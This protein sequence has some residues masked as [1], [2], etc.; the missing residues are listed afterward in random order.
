MTLRTSPLC[1]RLLSALK[2]FFVGLLGVGC[3]CRC[4]HRRTYDDKQRVAAINAVAPDCQCEKHRMSKYSPGVVAHSESLAR[5]VFSPMHVHKKNGTILPSIFSHVFS[6]GCSIQRNSLATVAELRA[7]VTDFIEEDDKRSWRGI[8]L[9]DCDSIRKI[10]DESNRR[11]A[12][13]YDSAEKNNPSHGEICQTQYVIDEADQVELRAALFEA[14]NHG[15][16]TL[17]S[18]YRNGEVWQQI[19]EDLRARTS[20]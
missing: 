14:F 20:P 15:V 6:A 10:K 19:P 9:A 11:L 12:C 3:K 13:V 7:F 18:Q 1:S 16:A 17:P 8:L 5:F 2:N 4:L